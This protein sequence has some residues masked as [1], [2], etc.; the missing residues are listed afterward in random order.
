MPDRF[1]LLLLSEC[2]SL[3]FP[4]DSSRLLFVDPGRDEE[5]E[6]FF[7]MHL[8]ISASA[9]HFLWVAFLHPCRK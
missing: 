7:G 6:L 9:T 3:E 1:S 5:G 2:F 4:G 8:S